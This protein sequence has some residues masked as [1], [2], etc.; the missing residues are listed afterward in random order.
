MADHNATLFMHR[1]LYL[2]SMPSCIFE[3]FSACL[4]YAKRSESNTGMVL[5]TIQTSAQSLI[6]KEA[7]NTAPTPTQQLSRTQ[8]LFMYE[9][10]RLFDGDVFLRAQG[11]KD[12]PLLQQ[13]IQDLCCIRDNLGG[14]EGQPA[15]TAPDW[16]VTL[17]FHRIL[18][19]SLP[20]SQQ[21]IF[22]ESLRRTVFVAYSV[23]SL[24]EMMKKPGEKL[25]KDSCLTPYIF[26]D[27]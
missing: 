2:E 19:R 14:Q 12:L 9:V 1:S 5:R 21:W 8:A 3:C 15:Q 23:I 4:M 25:R 6:D 20:A 26:P 10:I 13:W 17:S 27:D 11:E 24:Y 22:D 7:S 18:G 16:K